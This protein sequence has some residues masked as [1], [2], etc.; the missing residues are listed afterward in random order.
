MLFQD[1]YQK[2]ISSRWVSTEKFKG[3][4]KIIKARLVD[5][6]FEEDSSKF[7][8]DSPTCGR[9]PKAGVF[10]C[11]FEF[12]EIGIH[13]YYRCIPSRW[14]IRKRGIFNTTP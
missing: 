6:G 8:K 10:G 7:R 11:S 14:I 3:E 2:T 4:E 1:T 5:R 12:L 13:R 9:E